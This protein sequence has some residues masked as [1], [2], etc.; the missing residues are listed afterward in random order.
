MENIRF[1]SNPLLYNPVGT[2]T[3][4]IS[5]ICNKNELFEQLQ[6]KLLL[7][8][9]FGYN[10]DALYDCLRDFHWIK[11]KKI[12]LVHDDLPILDESELK[13]YLDV[14][15]DAVLDWN[16]YEE[17]SLEVVF[18]EDTKEVFAYHCFGDSQSDCGRELCGGVVESCKAAGIVS[19]QRIGVATIGT[20]T[21]NAVAVVAVSKTFTEPQS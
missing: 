20:D 17:H 9:Y 13:T 3:A 6:E 8:D 12:A 18:S 1:L 19:S 7:P 14:L 21:A 10:W 16:E 4:H 11:Q 5:G 2:F 15:M